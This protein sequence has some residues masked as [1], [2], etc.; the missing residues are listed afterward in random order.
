MTVNIDGLSAGQLKA[1]QT[2]I[3]IVG[4]GRHR[5]GID[6][7]TAMCPNV[8]MAKVIEVSGEPVVF[9]IGITSNVQTIFDQVE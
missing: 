9:R 3:K 7:D 2:I 8:K 1:G 4:N 5:V 6:N